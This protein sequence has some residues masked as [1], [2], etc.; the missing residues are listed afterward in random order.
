MEKILSI[1]SQ[2]PIFQNLPEGDLKRIRGIAKDKFF[3]KGQ[4]VFSE[5]DDG[6]SY[7][8]AHNQSNA[9][10][11]GQRVQAGELLGYVGSTGNAS[12]G[13]PHLHF[14]VHPGGGAAVNPYPWVRPLCP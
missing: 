1:I 2:I 5:G 10:A 9:V 13:A 12:Y 6:N 11:K 7:Y 14:D 3:N 8:Y 4:T